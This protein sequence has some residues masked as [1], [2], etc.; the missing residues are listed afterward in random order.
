M[1]VS[2]EAASIIPRDNPTK[3]QKSQAITP[4]SEKQKRRKKFPF[5]LAFPQSTNALIRKRPWEKNILREKCAV[6]WG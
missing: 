3:L 5:P 1:G 6:F 2:A 4:H